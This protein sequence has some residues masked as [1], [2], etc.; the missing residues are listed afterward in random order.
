MNL[1]P[2]I[3]LIAGTALAIVPSPLIEPRYFI[4]PYL[5]FRLHLGPSDATPAAQARW[6]RAVL[7]ELAFNIVVNAGTVYVFLERPFAWP[8]E[9][10]RL[11][12]FMW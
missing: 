7:V 6:Q 12:R 2:F 11:Q 8:N 3:A 9:P 1:L 4:V 10:G 5:L